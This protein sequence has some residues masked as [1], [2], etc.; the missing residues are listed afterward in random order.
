LLLEELKDKITNLT[1][2]GGSS[3]LEIGSPK[4]PEVVTEHRVEE[5]A[6]S[7]ISVFSKLYGV[8]HIHLKDLLKKLELC[9]KNSVHCTPFYGLCYGKIIALETD[10]KYG[11]LTSIDKE[12]SGEVFGDFTK[13]AKEALK[14]GSKDVAAV[15][16]CAAL[17]DALKRLAKINELNLADKSMNDVVN[18]LKR[19]GI[20]KGA[21]STLIGSYITL[22]NRTFH[23]QWDKVETTDVSSLI[24]FTEQLLL[25]NFS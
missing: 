13:S 10:I 15:L 23:A 18:S 11:L 8:T 9:Q 6:S 20:L 14:S 25:E 17:E 1:Y 16:G 21:Q 5:I 2:Q 12:I 19:N 4:L 22:R 7:T 3:Y 24:G